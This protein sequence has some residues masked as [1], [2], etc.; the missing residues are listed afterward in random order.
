MVSAQAELI[1]NPVKSR[2]YPRSCEVSEC[3]KGTMH[4]KQ[5]MDFN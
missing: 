5:A 4:L 2:N 1:G 3:E